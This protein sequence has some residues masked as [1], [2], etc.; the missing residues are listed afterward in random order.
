MNKIKILKG[1][2]L[3]TSVYKVY[4]ADCHLPSKLGRKEMKN[5]IVDNLFT[6]A[7]LVY[8]LFVPLNP[9]LESQPTRLSTSGILIV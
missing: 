7:G 8:N 5:R 3:R 9:L 4:P 2:I 1:N 6:A